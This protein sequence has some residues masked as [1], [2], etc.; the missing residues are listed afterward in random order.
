MQ[1][2]RKEDA[3]MLQDSNV[4]FPALIALACDIPK[5]KKI[6]WIGARDLNLNRFLVPSQY[7]LH[8]NMNVNSSIN[9]S[10]PMKSGTIYLS[11]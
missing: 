6:R 5:E 10:N 8:P 7:I 1:R 9:S 11:L 4:L 2:N 3:Q